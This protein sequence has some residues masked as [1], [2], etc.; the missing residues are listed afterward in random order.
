MKLEGLGRYRLLD[1]LPVA[2]SDC[3][4]YV[5]R[6]EDEADTG[7]P[8]YVAKLLG[9]VRGA[10]AER[11]RGQFEHE[12]KL[13]KSINHASIPT[14]HAA[15]EQDGVPYLVVDRVEGL[16]LSTLLAGDGEGRRKLS[17]E[18]AVYVMG[19]LADALRYVHTLEFLGDDG[20][21]P[22]DVLHRDLCPDNVLLSARGDVVLTDFGKASSRWLP[23]SHDD[24][25]SGHPGYK[26]PERW[27]P[28]SR[29]DVK[30][31]LFALAVMLWESL[32]G[33]RCFP[34]ETVG[35]VRDAI[36]RFDISQ[37]SRRV[38]GLSPKLSEV[39]RRNLDRDP[40]RR[41]PDAYKM[42]QRLAQAP[43]AQAAA[44]SREQL[45]ALVQAATAG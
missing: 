18:V 21:E 12:I 35:E 28:G 43:E 17:K 31:D 5:A 41:Y 23:A 34:G 44:D 14:L 22:L 25:E 16:P 45:G 24:P 6:H 38:S 19:Q 4:F 37:A 32:R 20:P 2:S 10:D 39:L 29:A 1:R 11:R 30:T 33:E 9:M 42:L 36:E 40:Q 27:A 8:S 3:E 15:G 7:T 13:L 26:A